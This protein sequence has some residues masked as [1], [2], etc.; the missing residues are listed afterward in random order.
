MTKT[1]SL[2]AVSIKEIEDAIAKAISNLTGTEAIS[3]ISSFVVSAP[4][5]VLP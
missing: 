4:R 5:E 3:T 2:K 1:K